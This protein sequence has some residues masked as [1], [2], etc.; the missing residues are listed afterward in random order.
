MDGL[1]SIND[2]NIG[3]RAGQIW[4]IVGESHASEQGVRDVNHHILSC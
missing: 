3:G 1:Q 4:A 2:V